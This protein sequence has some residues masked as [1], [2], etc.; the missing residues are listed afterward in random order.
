MPG[1]RP[2]KKGSFGD[3][4]DELVKHFPDE[5][6]GVRPDK[7]GG[8]NG[9]DGSI[10]DRLFENAWAKARGTPSRPAR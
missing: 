7:T 8:K 1:K 3:H 6:P 2:V 5:R 10:H 9:G 4:F